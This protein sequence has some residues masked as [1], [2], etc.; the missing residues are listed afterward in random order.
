MHLTYPG[1]EVTEIV[2]FTGNRVRN[3]IFAVRELS[4]EELSQSVA[5]FSKASFC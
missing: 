3:G 4:S 5:N 1:S 2:H